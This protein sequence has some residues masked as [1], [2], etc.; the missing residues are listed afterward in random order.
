[1]RLAEEGDAEAGGDHVPVGASSGTPAQDIE[2]AIID[3]CAG[4]EPE[5]SAVAGAVADGGQDEGTIGD[6]LSIEDE[7]SP[8]SS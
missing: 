4:A 6:L 5:I 2:V 3:R 1:M 8:R 7:S